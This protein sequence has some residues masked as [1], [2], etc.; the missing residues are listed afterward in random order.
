MLFA[1]RFAV[2][3]VVACGGT[4][5]VPIDGSTDGNVGDGGC[6]EPTV[7]AS[8]GTGD[9]ACQPLGDPCCVGYAWICQNGAWDK[10]GLGCAC[11]VGAFSCGASATCS[12]N[13]QMCVDQA[14]GI[15]FPDGSVPPDSFTCDALPA[16]CVSD[17]TCACVTAQHP[18]PTQ[19]ASCD[20]TGSGVTVHCM[21]E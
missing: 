1:R 2:L 3:F 13:S 6:I 18:C 11:H 16:A 7:G 17:P 4:S 20:I 14:P 8:C 5:V 19:V 9:K 10:A 21:G 15:A 12:S